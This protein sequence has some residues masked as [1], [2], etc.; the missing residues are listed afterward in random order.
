MSSG[1]GKNYVILEGLTWL[2]GIYNLVVT[3]LDWKGGGGLI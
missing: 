1:P 3:R 2:E